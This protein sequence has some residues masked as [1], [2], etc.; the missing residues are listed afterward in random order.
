MGI[1]FVPDVGA[2]L[3]VVA[4]DLISESYA[5]EANEWLSYIMAAGGYVAAGMNKGGEFTKNLA[6][7][8]FPWA[9]KNIY[10]R[11]RGGMGGVGST[12]KL[13]ARTRSRVSRYPASAQEAPF[14]G[15]KLT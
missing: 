12:S 3:S 2:P 5:P 14:Q 13:A 7:A 11:I 10:S 1:K 8:S 15:V 9:A 6:I 4:V